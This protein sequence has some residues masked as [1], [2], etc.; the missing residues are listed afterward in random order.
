[1]SARALLWVA[2]YLLDG[3][4]GLREPVLT[5]YDRKSRSRVVLVGTQHF[6]PASIA[7]ADRVVRA[8]AAT[9]KLRSVALESCETRWSATLV[10]QPAGTTLRA[11]LDGPRRA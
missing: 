2:F 8:E 7:L 1:M 5:I 9:G 4:C 6:N 10:A 11:V 3:V